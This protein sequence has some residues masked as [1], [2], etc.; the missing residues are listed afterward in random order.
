[1]MRSQPAASL[2]NFYAN[3]RFAPRPSEAE[4]MLQAKRR[5]AAQRER[6][7]RNYHQEQQYNRS[8]QYSRPSDQESQS[9]RKNAYRGPLAL[10]AEMSPHAASAGKERVVSPGGMT[11]DDRRELIARQ[12]RALYGDLG[13]P[14]EEG[15]PAEDAHTPRASGPSSAVASNAGSVTGGTRGSSPLAQFDPFGYQN[16]NGNSEGPVQPTNER[17]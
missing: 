15:Y 2:Q 4:Q 16:Q 13:N 1:M 7:L 11:E 8:M 17:M 12:H 6:D 5:Q 10:L 3:Q 14:G 9:T